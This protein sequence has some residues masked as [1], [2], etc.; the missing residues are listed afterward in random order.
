M[1][2]RKPT[3]EIREVFNDDVH[4]GYNPLFAFGFGLSYTSFEYSEL[5]LNTNKLKGDEKLTVT[6]KVKNTGARDGK[7]TVELYSRDMY[8][9]ITPSMKRLRIFK[10]LT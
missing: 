8:A 3:E 10:K 2:D 1:Y 6:V 9:S 7:H 4:T 5:S